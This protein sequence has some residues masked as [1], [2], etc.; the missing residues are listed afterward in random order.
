[1]RQEGGEAPGGQ[2][3]GP[4]RVGEEQVGDLQLPEDDVTL[5]G[6]DRRVGGCGMGVEKVGQERMRLCC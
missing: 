3:R 4:Q 6:V 1:V 5:L 2:R